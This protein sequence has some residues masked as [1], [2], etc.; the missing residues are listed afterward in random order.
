MI[1]ACCQFACD[2]QA[3]DPTAD[4]G[5]PPHEISACV[6]ACDAT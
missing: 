4:N 1:A 6:G 5:N 2:R 3:E